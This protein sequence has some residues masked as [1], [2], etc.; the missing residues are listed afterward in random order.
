MDGAQRVAA[1]TR[2]EAERLIPQRVSQRLRTA[3][4][5]EGFEQHRQLDALL[6]AAPLLAPV[7]GTPRLFGEHPFQAG[8]AAVDGGLDGAYGR[9]RAA[10]QVGQ[11]RRCAQ[12]DGEPVL[13]IKPST[14]AVPHAGSSHVRAVAA[15]AVCV[16][17]AQGAA[18]AR[19]A[20]R[21]SSALLR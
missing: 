6:V 16:H 19:D 4:A 20:K 17:S 13:I 12:C 1:V 9:A 5:C 3:V 8:L 2:V 11:V 10:S 7:G 21:F 15:S 14:P 18:S